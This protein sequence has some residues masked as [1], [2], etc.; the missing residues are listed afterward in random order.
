LTLYFL[1]PNSADRRVLRHDD[2]LQAIAFF[3]R[4]YLEF[5]E[6]ERS[7]NKVS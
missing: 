3:W 7:A 5:V 6:G 2:F 4:S 1:V